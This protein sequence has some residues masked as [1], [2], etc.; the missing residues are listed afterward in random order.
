MIRHELPSSAPSIITVAEP[1]VHVY[2]T[3]KE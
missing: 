1:A 3:M 2:A